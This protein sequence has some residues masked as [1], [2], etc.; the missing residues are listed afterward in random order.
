MLSLHF[1]THP[2]PRCSLNL[3][4]WSATFRRYPHLLTSSSVIKRK[5]VPGHKMSVSGSESTQLSCPLSPPPCSLHVQCFC[6][7][8]HFLWLSYP[9]AFQQLRPRQVPP[10]G[11]LADHPASPWL[12]PSWATTAKLPVV[13]WVSFNA[14]ILEFLT[15]SA[16]VPS[17]DFKT[18]CRLPKAGE[19]LPSP[20]PSLWFTLDCH[21]E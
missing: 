19:I 12:L 5:K 11:C 21:I 18:E 13:E 20:R 7:W 6:L 1:G 3:W 8:H 15:D 10:P 9:A 16:G 4:R 2:H 17:C 14:T